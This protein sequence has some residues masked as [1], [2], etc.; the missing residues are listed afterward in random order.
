LTLTG[1]YNVLEQ[2][3]KG[4]PLTPKEKSIHEQGIV[5][6][7]RQLHDELDRAVFDACGRG[8]L[9]EQLVG[10]PGAT[11][12]WPEKPDAQLDAEEELL[13]RLVDLS[14]QRAFDEKRGLVRWLR[15][16]Y[17]N[18]QGTATTQA[19]AALDI[20][21]AAIDTDTA[22]TP[23]PKT[24]PQ[25][26]QTLRA[27][28]AQYPHNPLPRNNSPK[29]SKTPKPSA[30]PKYSIPLWWPWDKQGRKAANTRL[31]E[32]N[33]DS[34]ISHHISQGYLTPPQPGAYLFLRLGNPRQG[35]SNP[36]NRKDA[37]APFGAS[38]ACFMAGR[39]GNLRVGRFFF[40]VRYC[41]PVQPASLSCSNDGSGIYSTI[42]KRNST[43]K[44]PKPARDLIAPT[45]KPKEDRQRMRDLENLLTTASNTIQTAR[46]EYHF[47]IYGVEFKLREERR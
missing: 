37:Q 3:R 38:R 17:Q 33:R 26:V 27:A 21:A 20:P 16:E 28:L 23:W 29:P 22:K 1:I 40:F 7:L 8:D 34:P 5:S 44:D 30:Y 12:P 9:A 32:G 43:M 42:Q 19:E 6:V 31:P 39:A 46:E 18:P 36:Y 14:H 13:K 35:C 15:P 45:I 25:Q 2:L 11:T 41:Y 47:L 24:I 10:C 4:E